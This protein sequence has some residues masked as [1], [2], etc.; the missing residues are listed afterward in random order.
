L[1]VAAGALPLDFEAMD[2]PAASA[3][4]VFRSELP[5]IVDMLRG[6]DLRQ[7][8]GDPALQACASRP[9]PV[10]S[11]A[12]SPAAA[13]RA[14]R[15]G[16]GILMEGM[17]PAHRLA[18][19]TA[20]YDESGGTGAR[21]LI[22]RVWLGQPRAELVDAQRRVYDS[23][24]GPASEFGGDQTVASHDPAALVEALDDAVRTSGADAINL[25]VHL[26][27]MPPSEVR[28]QIIRLG[29]EVVPRL[30]QRSSRPWC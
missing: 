19:L 28:E 25:R 1:G 24:A 26:P 23:Y 2:R 29:S 4:D 6:R 12:V 9:I 18:R 30:R 27:G 7:L 3:V 15:S 10:L 21:V 22:R 8:E 16:A 17:S 5:R 13:G 14:A 11:A 20:E